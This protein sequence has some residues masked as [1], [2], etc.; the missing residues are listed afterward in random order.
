MKYLMILSSIVVFMGYYGMAQNTTTT[1][2]QQKEVKRLSSEQVNIKKDIE[3]RR[4]GKRAPS[5]KKVS[6]KNNKSHKSTTSSNKQSKTKGKYCDK[7]CEGA[8]GECQCDPDDCTCVQHR[9]KGTSPDN[10]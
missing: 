3:V 10:R 5:S 6:L 2:S 4:S 1:E 7:V 9:G 8:H